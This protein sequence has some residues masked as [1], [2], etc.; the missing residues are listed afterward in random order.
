MY[1]NGNLTRALAEK[2]LEVI[3][4]GVYKHKFITVLFVMARVERGLHFK[5]D[6][7]KNKITSI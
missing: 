1:N 4:I 6:W 3:F 2:T 5:R 7:L